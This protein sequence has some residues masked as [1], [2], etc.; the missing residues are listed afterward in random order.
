MRPIP[1]YFKVMFWF[2]IIVLIQVTLV[3]LASMVFTGSST[4]SASQGKSGMN[5]PFVVASVGIPV[6]MVVVAIVAGRYVLLRRYAARPGGIPPTLIVWSMFFQTLSTGVFA[7][8][9]GIQM[10]ATAPLVAA[11]I[12]I[13]GGIYLAVLFPYLTR[14]YRAMAS[15]PITEPLVLSMS[16]MTGLWLSGV[17]FGV[18]FVVWAVSQGA[19]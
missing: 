5:L 16:P 7:L 13:A 2:L 14:L 15:A 4:P 18:I 12:W 11:A 3:L 9:A 19:R 8:L 17:A 6:G 1:I 10:W